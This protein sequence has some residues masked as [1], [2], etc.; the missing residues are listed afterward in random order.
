MTAPSHD[1]IAARYRKLFGETEMMPI[2]ERKVHVP[3]K[4][5]EDTFIMRL[6]EGGV[7]P[8]EISEALGRHGS[9]R[10]KETVASRIYLLTGRA[11]SPQTAVAA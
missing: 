3:F 6:S 5:W 11:A 1:A 2:R 10:R 9:I 4:P 7:K 8:H